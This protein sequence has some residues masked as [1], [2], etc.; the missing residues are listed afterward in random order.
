MGAFHGVL[1]AVLAVDEL[2]QGAA[3]HAAALLRAPQ[4]I[5]V[6]VI[7]LLADDLAVLHIGHVL[8]AAVAGKPA[9]R[10]LPLSAFERCGPPGGLFC[11]CGGKGVFSHLGCA[12][13][14]RER[15]GSSAGCGHEAAP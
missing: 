6:H 8:A 10:R 7:G 5:L 2:T 3:F 11:V 1:D 9:G 14:E 4:R 15:G 13:R 12:A